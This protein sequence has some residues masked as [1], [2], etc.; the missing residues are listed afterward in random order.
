M[1]TISSLLY[2]FIIV[3]V[4]FS[5]LRTLSTETSVMS[6]P[7]RLPQEAIQRVLQEAFAAPTPNSFKEDACEHKV[8]C[9]EEKFH[10]PD[11][12]IVSV[13]ISTPENSP[14]ACS[15]PHGE[16]VTSASPS[17]PRQVSQPPDVSLVSMPPEPLVL[18]CELTFSDG[19]NRLTCTPTFH[20][21]DQSVLMENDVHSVQAMDVVT[22]AA[23]LF[24][25]LTLASQH[26]HGDLLFEAPL[27]TQ[28][29]MG[30]SK[31]AS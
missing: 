10:A 13:P 17:Q 23:D 20:T 29:S 22:D 5:A 11:S 15:L 30:S 16:A 19:D 27:Y 1:H 2:I 4:V 31:A 7:E 3:L 12:T 9:V 25:T 24:P 28:S 6:T 8:V 21:I 18:G 14:A 26:S